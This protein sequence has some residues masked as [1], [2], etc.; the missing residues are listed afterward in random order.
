MTTHTGNT[1]D[2]L[3]LGP[4]VARHL[5][6]QA[7]PYDVDLLH[8]VAQFI[9]KPE[10]EFGDHGGHDSRVGGRLVVQVVT[11]PSLPVHS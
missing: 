3:N 11:R 10:K 9:L 4:D 2:A 7:V 5:C 8:T 6:A 1:P